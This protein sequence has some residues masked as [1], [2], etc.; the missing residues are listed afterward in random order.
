M[1][2][3]V[4]IVP[5]TFIAQI[6]NLFIQ[7]YLIKRFLLKPINAVLEKRKE[8]ATA[9]IKEAEKAK[10]EFI[11]SPKWK[12]VFAWVLFGIVVLGICCWLLNIA[13]PEWA[14]KFFG[15]FRH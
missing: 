14:D 4:T 15:Y 1:Q 5:W 7:L 11:P 9:E 2:D 10:E 13:I 3:L 12:R 8:M 6:C